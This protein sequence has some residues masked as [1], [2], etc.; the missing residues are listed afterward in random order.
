M[1]AG[2]VI[3][4][5]DRFTSKKNIIDIKEISLVRFIFLFLT[6]LILI[7]QGKI[8]LRIK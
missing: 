8:Y 6:T 7:F 1:I 3:A 4:A 2:R 5:F